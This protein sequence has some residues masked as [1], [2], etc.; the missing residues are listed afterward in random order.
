MVGHTR[1]PFIGADVRPRAADYNIGFGE[2]TMS[3]DSFR[4]SDRAL[5]DFMIA[6]A[7]FVA[8]L[9]M[10]VVAFA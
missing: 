9:L 3:K 7:I 2:E 1:T 5:F 4:R 6:I 8:V 10:I